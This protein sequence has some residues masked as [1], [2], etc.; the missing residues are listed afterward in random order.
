VVRQAHHERK[1][2]QRNCPSGLAADRLTEWAA[3][4]PPA[5]YDEE[6]A[7]LL[8]RRGPQANSARLY[9]INVMKMKAQ[10]LSMRSADDFL[11]RI[12]SSL[13]MCVVEMTSYNTLQVPIS[14][15]CGRTPM[16]ARIARAC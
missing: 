6:A 1:E 15:S 12:A 10:P 9:L 3:F 11:F 4:S 7:D 14:L 13:V 8:Q 2:R 16:A 5:H